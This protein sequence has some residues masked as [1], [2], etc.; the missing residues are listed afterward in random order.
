VR[1][2]GAKPRD[3]VALHGWSVLCFGALAGLEVASS[4]D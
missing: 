4:D 1:E 2:R 3:E